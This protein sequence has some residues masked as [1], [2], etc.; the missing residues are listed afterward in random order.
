MI[1]FVKKKIHSWNITMDCNILYY[2]RKND[3]YS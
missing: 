3:V 1:I 2:D